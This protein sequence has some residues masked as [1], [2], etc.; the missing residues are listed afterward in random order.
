MSGE[1]SENKNKFDVKHHLS[2]R[3]RHL[4]EVSPFS[5]FYERIFYLLHLYSPER[6][7]TASLIDIQH[8]YEDPEERRAASRRR[9]RSIEFYI[10][11]WFLLEVSIAVLYPFVADSRWKILLLGL[12]GIRILDIFQITVNTSI[13]DRIR[14]TWRDQY[15]ESVPRTLILAVWNYLELMLCFGVVY[16]HFHYL[17]FLHDAAGFFDPYYFSAVTQL[18]IGFGDIHPGGPAQLA[19][20]IQ[21]FT[22]F[23]FQ[24]LILGRIVALLPEIK[25]RDREK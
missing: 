18:T 14:L 16:T 19:T 2:R 7:F 1:V 6:L 12:L 17:G 21:G 5:F 20:I 3:L 24:L 23:L 13:F 15:A 10:F 11:F 25:G 9:D 8:R 22:G 4:R